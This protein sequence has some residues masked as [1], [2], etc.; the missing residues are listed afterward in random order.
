MKSKLTTNLTNNLGLKI[1]AV[2]LAVI[3]WIIVVNVDDPVDSVTFRDIPVTVVNEEIV[4][5]TGKIYQIVDDT[6]TV[7]VTVSAPRSVLA[8]VT[9]KNIVAEADMREM[10]L[11]TLVPIKAYVKGYEDKCEATASPQNI[12]V[13][14][15]DQTKN[16]FPLTVDT[17]GTLRG[18][19][20]LGETKTNP[21]TVT[22]RG[23]ESSVANVAKAVAK[24]DVS[25]LSRDQELSAEL[26]LYDSEGNVIDQ[27]LL[28]NNLGDQGIT[29]SVQILSTKSVS[30]N[31]KVTGNPADGYV[32]T[33][34]SSEPEEIDICGTGEVLKQISSIDV[35]ADELSVEGL[36]EKKEVVLDI[37][38]YLPENVKLVD[39]KANNVIVTLQVEQEG[40]KV[41]EFP[42][43]SIGVNNLSDK[44][45]I[46]Y[47]DTEELELRFRG[48][49]EALDVLDIQ[50][51]V[52]IDMKNYTTAGT[53]EIPVSVSVPDS[54]ELEQQP[55]I[56]VVL[57]EKKGE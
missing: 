23:A 30:L 32:Y 55:V 42:V 37:Q 11:K 35:S 52:S 12:Q 17:T 33:G 8:K 19:Y 20:V 29:V 56:K 34:L 9:E 22:I 41:I 47:E 57:T 15:E 10:E 43:E 7:S 1:A 6:Q 54:V 28:T 45:K 4:T 25:G 5:N 40:V 49:K 46:S 38:K 39:E 53:Y 51:G 27:T 26:V 24:V 36:T 16:T 31:F 2:F 48:T 14:I 3:L 50:N 44:L 21:E 18:G 13:K